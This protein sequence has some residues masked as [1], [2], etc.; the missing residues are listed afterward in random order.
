MKKLIYFLVFSVF[1]GTQIL[2]ID[3]GFKLS[4]YRVL[5]LLTFGFFTLMFI[6]ND[7]RL[8]FYPLKLSSTYTSF[9]MLWLFYSL[10]SIA[11]SQNFAGWAK[12]NIF[13]GIGVFSI[14]FIHL[15]V[16]EK[17]DILNLFRSVAA[18]VTLHIGLGLYELF[19]A[20]YFWASNHFMTKYRPAARNVFSRIPI[21]IYPNENDYATV[22]LMGSFFIFLLMRQAKN[23]YLKI[24]YFALWAS[25]FWLI[26]QTDSRA[27]VLAFGIGIGMMILA[28]FS[29]VISRKMVWFAVGAAGTA[30]VALIA[31]SASIRLKITEFLVLF[32][33]EAYVDYSNQNRINLIRNGFSFLRESF[34]FGI[35]AGNIEHWM[36]TNAVF[37]TGG[38]S[39]MHNW[40]MEILTGYGLLIFVLYLFVY[41]SMMRKAYFYYRY[42]QDAFLRKASLSILGYLAAFTLSSIS[43][44]SNIINE[45]QW[46][47]FGV[48]IAFFS[49]C[50]SIGM[51][52]RVGKIQQTMKSKTKQMMNEVVGGQHG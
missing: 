11:W 47:I 20:N 16:K 27:N 8:R 25:C 34:G 13:I 39:N 7:Q 44:A 28:Y 36:K 38:I 46:V 18:G 9:Y 14:V 43:S 24:G 12:A 22:L 52:H 31:A 40:W 50:E 32:N 10:V 26:Y 49:Y 23:T 5:F 15:F 48:I 4:M 45:W 19:T 1:L 41:I 3:I 35:G 17:K 21:S 2:A 42:S 6:N 30:G 33:P 29:R 51:E 37:R